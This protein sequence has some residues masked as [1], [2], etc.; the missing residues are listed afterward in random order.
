MSSRY[1]QLY[2]DTSAELKK[3]SISTK[4]K[5][6]AQTWLSGCYRRHRLYM[7]DDVVMGVNNRG[8]SNK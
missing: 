8:A 5:S 2:T 1:E 3:P 7:D 6:D 4:K